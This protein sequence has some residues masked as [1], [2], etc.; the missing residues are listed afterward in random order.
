[1]A[2]G[3]AQR[4][5]VAWMVGREVLT[6]AGAG[7]LLALPVAGAMWQYVR[8]ELYGVAPGDPVIAGGLLISLALVGA[9]AAQAPVRKALKL[10]PTMALR[11]E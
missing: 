10:D 4:G 7:L 8:S 9:L 1:V 2:L 11:H 3:R 6:L 5:A